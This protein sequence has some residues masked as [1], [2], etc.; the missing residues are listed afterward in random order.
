MLR[1]NIF[2]NS[3]TKIKKVLL[4]EARALSGSF[5]IFEIVRVVFSQSHYAEMKKSVRSRLDRARF[6]GYRYNPFKVQIGQNFLN[7]TRWFLLTFRSDLNLTRWFLLDSGA[8]LDPVLSV[9][10]LRNRILGVPKSPK[11]SACG[12]PNLIGELL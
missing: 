9:F 11:F 6:I 3:E 8:F 7:L 4:G 12:G 10:P 5:G 2:P 1:N